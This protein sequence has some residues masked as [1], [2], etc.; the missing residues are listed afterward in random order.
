MS[1]SFSVY[2]DPNTNTFYLKHS[3][4]TSYIYSDAC[5]DIVICSG[6][7]HDNMINGGIILELQISKN[8]KCCCEAQYSVNDTNTWVPLSGIYIDCDPGTGSTYT[9]H[10]SCLIIP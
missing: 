6:Y 1:N 2:K 5:A 3:N 10:P 9:I 7:I 4:G 8:T